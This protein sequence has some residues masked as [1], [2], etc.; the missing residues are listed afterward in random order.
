MHFSKYLLALVCLPAFSV[1]VTPI[2]NV[3]G[4]PLTTGLFTI[5]SSTD[6]SRRLDL[7][8]ALGNDNNPVT[9]FKPDS[10]V[11]VNQQW[12]FIATGAA[13]TFQIQNGISTPVFLS[14][15]N[16]STVRFAQA[17]VHSNPTALVI[18]AFSPGSPFFNILFNGL[19]LTYW[20]APSSSFSSPLTFEFPGGALN[21]FQNWTLIPV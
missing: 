17:V 7:N 19:A 13:N 20:P 8:K 12:S 4:R 6:P 5:I 18:S 11:S 15:P 9:A 3:G 2:P 21:S 1:G 16:A 10:V 14:S